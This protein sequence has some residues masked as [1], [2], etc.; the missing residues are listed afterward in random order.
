MIHKRDPFIDALLSTVVWEI[1]CQNPIAT[2]LGKK[3]FTND[4]LTNLNLMVSKY[5]FKSYAYLL[6]KL[7]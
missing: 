4:Q 7:R 5:M 6:N 1:S 3:S 2:L